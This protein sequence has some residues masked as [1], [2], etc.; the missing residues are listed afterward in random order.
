MASSLRRRGSAVDRP[1]T[2]G[3]GGDLNFAQRLL[4]ANENA[5]TNIADLWV[6]AAMNV[7]NENPF[8]SDTEMGSDGES[9]ECTEGGDEEEA[10]LSSTPT[11]RTHIG[12]RTDSTSSPNPRLAAIRRPSAMFGPQTDSRRPSTSQQYST[13]VR[14]MSASVPQGP[15]GTPRFSSS[16]P[17]IFAHP[18]VRTPDAVM[19]A[20]QLLAR[21]EEPVGGESLPPILE[22]RS[23]SQVN[24]I[25]EVIEE[26]APSLTS[27]LPILIIVQYGLLAL[28]TTTHDQVFM[29]YL[30]THYEAG[31]LNLDPGHF[32]QLIA[33]MCLAQIFYQFYLYPN[34][35][36]PR[37]RYSHLAMF[38]IGSSLFIPSYLTV[39]LYRAFAAPDD[40]GNFVVMAALAVSTALR[41]CAITFAYTA[42]SI[43]LNYMTPPPVV[44]I[45]NGIAQSIVSLARCFGPVLGGYLWS[46]ST[47]DNPSGYP[48]GFIA[49]AGAC[50][51]AV[52][53]SFMIR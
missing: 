6:A 33:L 36:P 7:D 21:P 24:P 47:Q 39:I 13:P 3:E 49:C 22:S 27:Q 32:A 8:E 45:A 29:S 25:E 50:T 28:H 4:M 48:I 51:L 12:T 15:D 20:Q 52:I 18:G 46:V 9:I 2:A 53:Q 1:Q 38:R 43:L 30:V 10:I 14:R 41:Y 42:V 40:D 35:G 23:A 37:G 44:G 17:S 31:G 11:R 5:V 16:V 19:D 26:K 34:I